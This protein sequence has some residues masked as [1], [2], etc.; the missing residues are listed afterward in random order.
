MLDLDN[1]FEA[2][3]AIEF[4]R[5]Q[6]ISDYWESIKKDDVIAKLSLRQKN[7]LFAI[8]HLGPC[9]LQTIMLHTGLSSSAASAVVDKLVKIGI[10]NRTRN[11]ENRREILVSLA[12]ELDDH[13]RKINSLFRHRIAEILSECSSDE[14]NSIT[15]NAKVLRQKFSEFTTPKPH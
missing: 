6:C 12:P 15:Q 5:R 1:F 9:S 7:Y 8:K 4:L 14:L 10:V 2:H 13:F 3:N 11:S